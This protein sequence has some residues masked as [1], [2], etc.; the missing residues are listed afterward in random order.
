MLEPPS[1][2]HVKDS[3]DEENKVFERGKI[4]P[5][6][7]AR[8]L[9][10]PHGTAL[11]ALKPPSPSHVPDYVDFNGMVCKLENTL[12]PVADILRSISTSTPALSLIHI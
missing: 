11:H 3:V 9:P 8:P 12:P 1:P 4:W 6:S 10:L 7:V 2:S 5:P